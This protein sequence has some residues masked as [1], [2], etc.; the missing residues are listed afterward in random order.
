MQNFQLTKNKTYLFY[1]KQISNATVTGC[2]TCYN[3]DD[4]NENQEDDGNPNFKENT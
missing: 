1:K 4:K 2:P 3:L